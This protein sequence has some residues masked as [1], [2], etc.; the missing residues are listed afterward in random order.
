[1]AR[2]TA[3]EVA[4]EA[5][6]ESTIYQD[7]K[8]I[9]RKLGAHLSEAYMAKVT[10]AGGAGGSV[11]DV[12]FEPAYIEVWDVANLSLYKSYFASDGAVH[13]SVIDTGA[14]AT[15]LAANANPP[16][17]TQVAEGDWTVALPTQ[18]APDGDTVVVLIKGFRNVA[19]SL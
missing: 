6:T 3:R 9:V 7:Q 1:M 17:L 4:I 19:G 5:A 10:G 16:V 2:E 18:M 12:P 11:E 14:G 15:D 8:Q 13:M